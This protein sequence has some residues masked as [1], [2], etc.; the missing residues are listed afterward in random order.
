[1]LRL[2]FILLLIVNTAYGQNPDNFVKA[3]EA[4]D[5]AKAR[6]IDP[7]S[8]NLVTWLELTKDSNP[9]FYKLQKFIIEHPHWP[10]ID[11]LKRKIEQNS[12]KN[13]KNTDILAWFGSYKPQTILGKKKYL[14]LI[15]DPK[16]QAK[17]V[18]EIWQEANFSK[19]E[20]KKFLEKYGHY[21]K[22]SNYIDRINYLLFNKQI[23]QAKNILPYISQSSR[24]L[25]QARIEIQ[26]GNLATIGKYKSSAKHIGILY[27][28]ASYYNKLDSEDDMVEVMKLASKINSSYHNYFWSMKAKTIRTL[29]QQKEYQTAY[30]F[31]SMHGNLPNADYSEAE[32]LAGWISL[33]F[34]NQPKLAVTHFYNMYNKVK[35]PMSVSRASYWLARSYEDAEDDISAKHW[36]EEASKYFTSF[37]G[38]LA[39]CK[40][41]NCQVNIPKDPEIT[42]EDK[43]H[44]K[45]N[46]LV[47]AALLLHKSKKYAHLVQTFLLQAVDNSKR[48]GEI[49]LITKLGFDLNRYHLSV[50][51]AKHASY[52]DTLILRSSYPILDSVYKEHELDPALVMALIRQESVFNHKAVSCAG[53]T[54]LMQLMP[55]VAKETAARLNILFKK[56]KLSDPHFNTKLGTTHLDKLVTCYN[57]SYI[58]SIAAYNAG[59]KPVQKWLEGNGDPRL[60]DEIEDIVDWVERISFYETRNYVQRVLEGKSIYH[61]LMTKTSTLPIVTDLKEGNGELCVVS[62]D[63]SKVVN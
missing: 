33:R 35:R 2:F 50:E 26:N 18:K 54:G 16:L 24:V 23:E 25:Y 58:L 22:E 55:H 12:F 19:D 63:N 28:I 41:N 11:S 53:A 46:Q 37:Y 29:I 43:K 30:L 6:K 1:M 15:E 20:Q 36:Y 52:K 61:L 21:L 27:D 45:S 14:S 56:E 57:P 5:W 59:D 4:E 3:I 13:A 62:V 48:I 51:A 39:I 31:A 38:Q 9:D 49:S 7:N 60:M 44:F 8:S 32:W 17:Y 10:Q 40:I 47:N 42:A 34:L